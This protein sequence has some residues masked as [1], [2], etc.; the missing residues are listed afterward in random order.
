MTARLAL[1]VALV[2][3]LAL[4]AACSADGE[5]PTAAPAS[6]SEAVATAPV[7]SSPMR[8][9]ATPTPI[10]A[11]SES[12]SGRADPTATRAAPTP[13]AK[14]VAS[15]FDIRTVLP[16]DAIPS[17]DKPEF[18]DAEQ[19]SELLGDGHLIIGLSVGG[20]HRAYSTAFLSSHEIVNDTVGG[21]PVA[22][23]W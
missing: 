14:P 4:P 12:T 15:G 1:L 6:T 8:V 5:A 13:T 11:A 18:L 17:I 16:R 22:V 19:A 2:C 20:E 21:E 10:Q 9:D 23:T 3:V 7:E